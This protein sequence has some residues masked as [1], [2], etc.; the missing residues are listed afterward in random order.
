VARPERVGPLR[1]ADAPPRADVLPVSFFERPALEVARDLL[2]Q[3]LVS[4]VGGEVVAG[5][6]VETEAYCGLDDPASHACTRQGIT[7]RNR[8]MYGPPGRAYVYRSYGMHWCMNV[9]TDPDGTPGAV[10]LRGLDPVM[11]E[12]VM[13]RRR[14]DRRP[15]AA[16]PGRLGEAMGVTGALYGHDLSRPPLFLVRGE[17][18]EDERVGV[19][20]RV[21]V[22]EA[23]DRPYRFYVRGA[24]GVSRPEGWGAAPAARIPTPRG[25]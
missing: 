21:G 15:L 19:S 3:V 5:T 20:V 8:V 14:G 16:G 6:I 4:C 24:A 11:G 22:A 23:A 9:V 2:G 25:G 17:P 13:R 18:V 1:T 12:E 10:L 7:E